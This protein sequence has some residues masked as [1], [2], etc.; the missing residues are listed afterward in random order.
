MYSLE[1]GDWS[2]KHKILLIYERRKNTIKGNGSIELKISVENTLE[3]K[4]IIELYNY[5]PNQSLLRN[6]F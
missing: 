6:D 5:D 3:I 4:N 1:F 2:S